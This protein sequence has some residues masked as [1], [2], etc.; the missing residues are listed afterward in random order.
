MIRT[1]GVTLSGVIAIELYK[2]FT[3]Q[4]VSP[5]TSAV[6]SSVLSTVLYNMIQFV[7]KNVLIKKRIFRNIIDNRSKFEGC[8]ILKVRNT[9]GHPYNI[10]NVSYNNITGNYIINGTT[11]HIDGLQ[12]SC[13]N[14]SSLNF[15]NNTRTMV[16]FYNL[17]G[18]EGDTS[19]GFGKL[20]LDVSYKQGTGFFTPETD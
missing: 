1:I 9:S 14:S 5:I 8:W 6:T 19:E 11:Y 4:G 17:Q 20:T 15:Q 18:N 7:V 12:G 16:Y 3:K 2:H 13:F 10:L